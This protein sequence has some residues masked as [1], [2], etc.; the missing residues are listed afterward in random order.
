MELLKRNKSITVKTLCDTLEA[1][2]ATIRRDLAS[3]EA[4]GKLERTHG[5]AMLVGPV[6]LEYEETFHQK[7]NMNALQKRAIALKA[8]DF[9]KDNDS[10]AM[11]AGTTNLELAKLI[12][13]SRLR[14]TVVTNSTNVADAV[15]TNEGVTLYVVGGKLRLNT[16]ATVGTQ[17]VEMVRR[18]QVNK[19]FIGVNGITLDNGF[20]TPDLEEADIKRAL[21]SIG[22]QRFVLADH[23]KFTKVAICQ[24]APVS[25]VDG[26][27]TDK[28]L[29][30]ELMEAYIQNDVQ[31]IIA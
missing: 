12:G 8:Y 1:S 18:F 26:I 2:E 4:D 21:L 11:D 7:E 13:K 20:T 15:S 14:L 3:L 19:S 25:M 30:Q 29:E 31:V 6:P 27:I 5:G 17:A 23:S 16:L 22:V 9:L 28:E 10:I 24:I